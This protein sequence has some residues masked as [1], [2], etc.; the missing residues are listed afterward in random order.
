MCSTPAVFCVALFAVVQPWR[1]YTVLVLHGTLP[2]HVSL[3]NKLKVFHAV[4]TPAVR[5]DIRFSL[6]FPAAKGA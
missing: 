2:L 1:V 5:K 3:K 4:V 6:F